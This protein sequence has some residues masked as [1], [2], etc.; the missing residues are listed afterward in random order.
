MRNATHQQVGPWE[1]RRKPL[2]WDWLWCLKAPNS[3]HSVG[4]MMS[5]KCHMVW[6]GHDNDDEKTRWF[7][8]AENMDAVQLFISESWETAVAWNRKLP[9]KTSCDKVLI[10]INFSLRPTL[11][12]FVFA[13]TKK[14]TSNE[15]SESCKKGV[16][17][18]WAL[19]SLPAYSLFLLVSKRI[20]FQ[21][22]DFGW[23][24]QGF[25]DVV[26]TAKRCE[27]LGAEVFQTFF[28]WHLVFLG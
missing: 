23:E 10:A 6:P 19:W 7:F 27:F 28:I 14:D 4:S 13:W 12:F 11:F 1:N 16:T 15:V 8:A 18:W 26:L 20:K 25:G 24:N 3:W 5:L 21:C 17:F 9:N 22:L 2:N